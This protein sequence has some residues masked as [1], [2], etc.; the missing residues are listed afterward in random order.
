MKTRIRSFLAGMLSL[1]LILG[2]FGMA[3]ATPEA[4][5]GS[6]S[7]DAPT[8][9]PETVGLKIATPNQYMMEMV[10][11]EHDEES[12][13]TFAVFKLSP[14]GK[15]STILYYYEDA[16]KL[17]SALEILQ[18]PSEYRKSVRD[19][20]EFHLR[21]AMRRL[22]QVNGGG[23]PDYT[24]YSRAQLVAVAEETIQS[25]AYAAYVKAMKPF[26]DLDDSDAVTL[27]KT[28]SEEEL[29]RYWADLEKATDN[30]DGVRNNWVNDMAFRLPVPSE[31]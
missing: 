13:L 5:P 11:Y 4:A 21:Q 29:A 24:Y 1:A 31:T 9:L 14:A 12:N 27:M 7:P 16:G 20:A 23:G 17:E 22:T 8:E 2:I 10:G 25:D 18:H 15:I 19:E 6:T 26:A 3:N 30:Y 28:Y